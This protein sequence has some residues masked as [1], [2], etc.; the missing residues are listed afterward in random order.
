MMAA[1]PNATKG[2]FAGVKV[3]D[4][5]L[6]LAGPYCTMLLA[7]QGA[8]VI[9][10]EPPGGEFARG[11]GPFMSEDSGRVMGGP[12]AS[13]NR[14]KRSLALDLRSRKARRPCAG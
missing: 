7:D 14:N 9:K 6:M 12:F 3:I 4:L 5:T 8:D 1:A 2:T 10:I 13:I 11:G